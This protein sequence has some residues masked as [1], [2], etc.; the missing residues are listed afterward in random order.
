MSKYWSFTSTGSANKTSIP[1]AIRF[2]AN[3]E[4]VEDVTKP[5]DSLSS[6]PIHGNVSL[7]FCLF[8]CFCF[9]NRTQCLTA[10]QSRTVG[11]VFNRLSIDSAVQCVQR[12][13]FSFM[14][15]LPSYHPLEGSILLRFEKERKGYQSTICCRYFLCFLNLNKSLL[16]M[17]YTTTQSDECQ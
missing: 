14:A 5:C 13:D 15:R 3:E 1:V 4:S 7:S 17:A 2:N 9:H 11:F 10:G 16:I 12:F 8:D 6:S